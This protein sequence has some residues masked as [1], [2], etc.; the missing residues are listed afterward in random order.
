MPLNQAHDIGE[1]LEV[2][3][4]SLPGTQACISR[5][6]AG[7]ADIAIKMSVSQ[8]TDIE[9][10]HVHLDWE[11]EHKA[12]HQGKDGGLFSLSSRP[13]V[14]PRAAISLAERTASNEA[15]EEG[16]TTTVQTAKMSPTTQP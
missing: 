2:L 8:R 3:I 7:G 6:N 15:H 14:S 12:E 5:S 16:R 13:D 1:R 9:R 11:T 10:C 4:E